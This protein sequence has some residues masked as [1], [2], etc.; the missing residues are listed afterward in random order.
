MCFGLAGARVAGDAICGGRGTWAACKGQEGVSPSNARWSGRST[1]GCRHALGKGDLG[2]PTMN[3]DVEKKKRT[4]QVWLCVLRN[5]S[6]T[7]GLAR[8]TP[9][10][11]AGLA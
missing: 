1:S 7:S 3:N 6:L 9:L 5:S 8:A 10:R 11:L 2:P 4:C